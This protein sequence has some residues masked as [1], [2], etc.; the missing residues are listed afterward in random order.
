MSAKAGLVDAF[1]LVR[2][3]CWGGSVIARLVN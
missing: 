3:Q 2:H 1:S